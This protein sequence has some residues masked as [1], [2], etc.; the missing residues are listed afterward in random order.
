MKDMLLGIA[1]CVNSLSLVVKKQRRKP[2]IKGRNIV[3]IQSRNIGVHYHVWKQGLSN[4]GRT[5]GAKKTG[6]LRTWS[7]RCTVSLCRISPM[8]P[9]MLIAHIISLIL[10][11]I[12][13]S[14]S[15]IPVFPLPQP[16]HLWH[17]KLRILPQQPLSLLCLSPR[18]LIWPW[19]PL[20]PCPHL[21]SW[22]A[23]T[24]LFVQCLIPM[25]VYSICLPDIR[26]A[27][28]PLQR[29]TSSLGKLPSLR[30]R[31]VFKWLVGAQQWHEVR[32]QG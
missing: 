7:I 29:S 1:A 19:Q 12:F 22:V 11:E 20:S 30:I 21:W 8:P 24:H 6:S 9:Y 27:S 15:M 2:P 13:W 31:S 23:P 5:H 25:G 16:Y 28:V 26:S 32:Y 18:L 17:L 3:N 14:Q 4:S 10:S